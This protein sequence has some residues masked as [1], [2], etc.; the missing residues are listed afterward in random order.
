MAGF[1]DAGTFIPPEFAI[2]DTIR[3]GGVGDGYEVRHGNFRLRKQS[4][5]H[6]LKEVSAGDITHHH[7]FPKGL[8]SVKQPIENQSKMGIEAEFGGI[9]SAGNLVSFYGQ[10]H[11]FKAGDEIRVTNIEKTWP[12]DEIP[13]LTPEGLATQAEIGTKPATTAKE[14]RADITGKLVPIISHMNERGWMLLP[15]GLTGLPMQP[16]WENIAPHPYIVDI[17]THGLHGSA[18]RF[19]ANTVQNH[20]DLRPIGA[21][22]DFALALGNEYNAVLAAM[23]AAIATSAP[24]W[25]GHNTDLLSAREYS[26]NQLSTVGGVMDNIPVNSQEFL[27]RGHAR[28]ST[29]DIPVSERAGGGKS[30]GSHN[31]YRPKTTTGTAEFGSPDG[32][33]NIH[34]WIA[35]NLILRRFTEKVAH[36]VVTGTPMPRF[37]ENPSLA[38]R[39]QNAHSISKDGEQATLTTSTGRLSVGQAWENFFHWAKPTRPDPDWQ[40]AETTITKSLGPSARSVREFFDPDSDKYMSGNFGRAMQSDFWGRTGSELDRIKAVN[41]QVAIGFISLVQSIHNHV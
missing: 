21:S 25:N 1:K 19:D 27:A 4:E 5:R 23:L 3:N 37:L 36:S 2:P 11:A 13:G 10:D 12:I 39:R 31:N 34:L 41:H 28:V 14:L 15:T 38:T 9:D 40:F 33:P 32:N 22:L 16:S 35:S 8:Q 29:G 6:T 24:F 26:R 20:V 7:L 30:N 17:M 18:L